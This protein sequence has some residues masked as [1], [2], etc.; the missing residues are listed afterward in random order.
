MVIVGAGRSTSNQ[1]WVFEF[2]CSEL[3]YFPDT[4]EVF[5]LKLVFGFGINSCLQG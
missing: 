5:V 4:K 3:L 2:F 1:D